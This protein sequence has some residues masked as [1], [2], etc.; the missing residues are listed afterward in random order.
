MENF[1]MTAGHC[2]I[3]KFKTKV[4]FC[5]NFAWLFRSSSK[6]GR[7]ANERDVAILPRLSVARYWNF[8]FL[9]F[10]EAGN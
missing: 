7:V 2:E 6:K 10:P 8:C 9:F 3:E 4:H 5:S 1:A